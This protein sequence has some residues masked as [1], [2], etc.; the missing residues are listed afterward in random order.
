MA[1]TKTTLTKLEYIHIDNPTL[2]D[3]VIDIIIQE[4]DINNLIN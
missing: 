3:E 4:L 2:I 1:N